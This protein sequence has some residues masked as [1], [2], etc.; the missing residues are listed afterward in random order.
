[1]QNYLNN[2]M[3]KFQKNLNNLVI[4][5]GTLRKFIILFRASLIGLL[6]RELD[7]PV[8]D[9]LLDLHPPMLRIGQSKIPLMKRNTEGY[10]FYSLPIK[11]LYKNYPF[12]YA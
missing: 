1:M 7:S 9:P 10:L 3:S 5:L 12:I 2:N 8:L 4:H 6:G 11:S